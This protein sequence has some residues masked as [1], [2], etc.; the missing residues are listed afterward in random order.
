LTAS[1]AGRVSH[2]H[3]SAASRSARRAGGGAVGTP[4]EVARL[5][6][7]VGGA[8]PPLRQ[9]HGR[10]SARAQPPS[11]PVRAASCASSSTLNSGVGEGAR[12]RARRTTPAGYGD[13]I[14]NPRFSA[15]HA[16]VFGPG[17]PRPTMGPSLRSTR[18]MNCGSLERAP[19][20]AAAGKTLQLPLFVRR[21]RQEFG[22]VR[23]KFEQRSHA[24]E[25]V[26]AS[27]Q[28]SPDARPWPSAG[29]SAQARRRLI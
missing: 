26:V 8:T 23:R 4:L 22:E 21:E 12:R 15:T 25:R 10:A 24:D 6:H 5:A 13:M 9:R 1:E 16:S 28:M 14:Y 18:A 27:P 20:R 19:V 17:F 7:F 2:A 29:S 11:F 3:P